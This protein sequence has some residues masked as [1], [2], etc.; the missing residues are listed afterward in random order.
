[1]TYF[2]IWSYFR[3]HWKTNEETNNA[4]GKKK[5]FTSMA[6]VEEGRIRVWNCSCESFQTY[7][8][9]HISQLNNDDTF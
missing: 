7:K 9:E 6:N 4:D 5:K 3:N 2:K 8:L 1:M